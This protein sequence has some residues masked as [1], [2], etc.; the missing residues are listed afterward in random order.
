MEI[1]ISSHSAQDFE[2]A[3]KNIPLI[4]ENGNWYLG[5]YDTGMPSRGVSVQSIKQTTTSTASGGNNVVTVTLT[6][7]TTATF[8]IKNGAKGDKGD[9]PKKGTDYFTDAE[10]NEMIQAV[11]ALLPIYAGEV[12]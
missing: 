5:E 1:Y 12:V 2:N 9:T 4:G 6:D 10:K 8:N 3:L 11:K 7:G